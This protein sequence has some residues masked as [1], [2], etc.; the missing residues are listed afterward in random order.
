MGKAKTIA[1]LA[2]ALT[3]LTACTKSQRQPRQTAKRFTNEVL[4]AFTPVKD[5]GSSSVCWIY[6]MLA[7]IETNHIEAGDSV[8]LSAK[9][10]ERKLLEQLYDELYITRGE[11]GNSTRATAADCLSML[12]TYGL[13]HYNAY[14]DRDDLSLNLLHGKVRQL[15]ERAARSKAG[16]E[17]LRPELKRL[18]DDA[19]GPEPLHVFML[20]AEYTPL[21]FAHSVCTSDEYE[22]LT[23]F[24]HHPFYQSFD[25]ELPDNTRG[26]KFLNLP[27]DTLM[28]RL[29]TAINRRQAVCWEG[30][31]SEPL[32]SFKKGTA[33][34]ADRQP[35]TQENR[36]R[37]FEQFQTTDD[38]CMAIVGRATDEQGRRYYIMKNS[39]GTAN[40]YG[41]L[42]Y[43]S[44]NYV[45]MKTIALFARR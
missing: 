40:P 8:N 42:M 19:M 32:F 22:A 34:L 43:I 16:M 27:L 26:N 3:L 38:H 24:T 30:D 17:R 9:F 11:R 35:P 33:Y 29:D 13:T 6:A 7:T 23:S 5:Q 44:E 2:L 15:A 37:Q 18:L 45:R 12:Q 1:A 21:E 39:W 31:V 20:G 14:S 10:L 36:Q 41:G 28:A 4:L 25:L